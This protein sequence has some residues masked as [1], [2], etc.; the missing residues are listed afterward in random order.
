ML[1]RVVGQVGNPAF[2]ELI[3]FRAGHKQARAASTEVVDL[4]QDQLD[5]SKNRLFSV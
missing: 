2:A 1:L 3:G 5:T 4:Q